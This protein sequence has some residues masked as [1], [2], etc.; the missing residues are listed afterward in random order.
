MRRFIKLH[1]D[2]VIMHKVLLVAGLIL[3]LVGCTPKNP[4]TVNYRTGTEGLLV[5]FS[6]DSPPAKVYKDSKLMIVLEVRNKGAYTKQ[7]SL[8]NVY[9]TGFDPN[10]IFLEGYDSTGKYANYPIPETAGKSPYMSEGGYNYIEV[11]ESAPVKV[12]YGDLTDQKIMA[13]TCYEYQT[14]ATPSV[15]VVSSPTAIYKDKICEPTTVTMTNQGAPVAVTK[16]QEQSMENM[17]SFIITVQNVGGGRVVSLDSLSS[18]PLGLTYQNTN[19]VNFGVGL[20]NYKADC[21]PSDGKIR[22]IDGKAVF[23]CR[24]PV[25]TLASYVSPLNIILNYGYSSSVTRSVQIANPPGS[26]Y[27]APAAKTGTG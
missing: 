5:G 26:T 10:A 7:A 3:L 1:P 13:T 20:S 11:T 16:V 19:I 2:E 6:K 8:G 22:L 17:V 9:L 15:C 14:I 4:E 25:E 18:C 23:F 21:T 27:T 12:P 24:F